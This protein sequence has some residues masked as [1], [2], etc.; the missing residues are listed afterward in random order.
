MQNSKEGHVRRQLGCFPKRDSGWGGRKENEK[1]P[2]SRSD[3]TDYKVPK[4]GA[5]LKF[6]FSRILIIRR[7][8]IL[9]VEIAREDLSGGP[10]AVNKHGVSGDERSRGR[11]QKYYCSG[12]IHGLANTMQPSNAFDYIRA[13]RGIG[14]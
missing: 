8:R 5:F 4:Q 3:L 11:G 13:K 1:N 6:E 9:I 10:A 7:E 2:T 14:K 12:D